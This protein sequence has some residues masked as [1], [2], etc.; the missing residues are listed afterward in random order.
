MDYHIYHQLVHHDIEWCSILLDPSAVFHP[1]PVPVTHGDEEPPNDPDPE[2]PGPGWYERAQ[3]TRTDFGSGGAGDYMY[4]TGRYGDR[5]GP[6]LG[7]E[8]STCDHQYHTATIEREHRA[9]QTYCF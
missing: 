4:H 9:R 2:P 7:L 5:G 1:G 3:Y 8:Y 6:V